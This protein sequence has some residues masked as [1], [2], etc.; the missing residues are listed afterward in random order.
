MSQQQ[1]EKSDTEQSLNFTELRAKFGA[2]AG[3]ETEANKNKKR[4]AVQQ[5]HGG[6]T[7]SANM[8]RNE[9]KSAPAKGE[10]NYYIELLIFINN[11]VFNFNFFKNQHFQHFFPQ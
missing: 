10:L 4:N 7:A 11:F 6:T 8:N 1:K 9:K 2:C 5:Q 3:E